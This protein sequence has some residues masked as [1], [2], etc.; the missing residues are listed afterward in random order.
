MGKFAKGFL[1]IIFSL[2]LCFGLLSCGI[3]KLETPVLTINENVVTWKKINNATMYEIS[4]NEK[5]TSLNVSQTSITLEHL[6][7]VSVRAIGD[8]IT[9]E[10]SDW[11]NSITYREEKFKV[12]WQIDGLVTVTSFER[13]QIPVYTK[14]TPV[15]PSTPEYDY[16]FEGWDINNDNIVDVLPKV[17]KDLTCIA[18]FKEI[19][20]YY[21]VTFL[22]FDNTLLYEEQVEYGNLPTYNG[23]PNRES[24][25]KYSYA[26]KSWDK[27]INE[28]TNDITYKA[29]YNEIINKYTVTF[30]DETGLTE[31]AKVKVN[32]GEKAVYPKN[33]PMK[34]PSDSHTYTFIGWMTEKDGIIEDDLSNVV[35]DRNV[36][37]SFKEEVKKV[38]IYILTNNS[39]GT[40]SENIIN[41]VDYGTEIKILSNKIYINDIIIEAISLDNTA[42]FTYEFVN[43]EADKNVSN[44]TKIIANFN[45]TINKYKITWMNGDTTLDINYVEYGQTPKYNGEIPIKDSSNGIDYIF[46]GW[47]PSIDSVTQD[48]VYKAQFSEKKH[49]YQVIFYDEDGSS[50]LGTI[51]TNHGEEAI[52]PNVLPTKQS[53]EK[54]TYTFVKW[55]V[56]VGNDQEADLSNITSNINVYAQYKSKLREYTVTFVDYDGSKLYEEQLK[57]GSLPII[58]DEPYRDKY[59]FVGW[60][61]EIKEVTSDIVYT[62]CYIRIYTII[63]YDYNYKVLK[64]DYVYEGENAVPPKTPTRNGYIFDKW[65]LNFDNINSDLEI[66]A[67][68][69]KKYTVNFYD[70]NKNLIKS[71]SV[72]EGN[73]VTPPNLDDIIGLEFTKWSE[74]L[75]NINTDLEVYPIY[76]I[77]TYNVTFNMPSGEVITKQ[78]VE[79]GFNALTPNIP[80]YYYD[81]TDKSVKLF[82][83]FDKP[84]ENITSDTVITILYD[85][86]IT[87]SYVVFDNIISNDIIL[88]NIYLILPTNKYIYGLEFNLN[89]NNNVNI[90]N[91]T[92]NS[93][94]V[95]LNNSNTLFYNYSN[96]ENSFNVS[97]SNANGCNCGCVKLLT[98][99]SQL[100]DYTIQSE[101]TFSN[102][103]IINLLL[104]DNLNANIIEITKVNAIIINN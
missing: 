41:N 64:I 9:Y 18:V 93:N 24:T 78:T 76:K 51:A 73:N 33:N 52:Y 53:T 87:E 20:R 30:Y 57:Y 46:T 34:N 90:T 62:A 32:Y 104:S 55:V 100:N 74:D 13:N 85:T 89:I 27:E 98:I 4:I 48:A 38:T 91:V 69:I 66:Y 63:F 17:T 94:S 84:L 54:Y 2:I 22:N 39:Y 59:S 77:K 102:N 40:T 5:I 14:A 36:Y 60:D 92:V 47:S 21:T 10:N 29:L 103:S 81:N 86:P 58:D 16:I 95:L 96:K 67:E 65:N 80:E 61:S 71:V 43:W 101:S 45:R 49:Q 99:T 19:K 25:D 50:I 1:F 56:S 31:L 83:G 79:H 75:N 82:T 42:Q 26:F 97:W 28:V 3:E 68:Y 11:S 88:T 23:K 6:D 72:G 70:L 7:T 35:K 37:A 44:D 15:K 8:G 12:T